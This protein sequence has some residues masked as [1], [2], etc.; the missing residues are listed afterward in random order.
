M[1]G[2]FRRK[3]ALDK[4]IESMY[5]RHPPARR[6]DLSAATQLAVELTGGA[7]DKDLLAELARNLYEGPMPY[8][9][10]DLAVSVALGLFK[11]TPPE[12]RKDLFPVQILARLT[13]G[14][15]AREGKV[16]PILAHTFE[17]TLYRDYAPQST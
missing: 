4:L 17:E 16:V 1:F 8:S 13:V 6:A 12:H 9:T 14:L 7:F 2:L 10:H 15:W 3:S 11:R 5:G